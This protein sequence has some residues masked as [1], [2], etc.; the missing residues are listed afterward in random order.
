M[1][2]AGL[3]TSP[4][5]PDALHVEKNSTY[6]VCPKLDDEPITSTTEII[7]SQL[8]TCPYSFTLTLPTFSTAAYGLL[9][10]A[11]RQTRWSSSIPETLIPSTIAPPIRQ[12]ILQ[13]MPTTIRANTE[14]PRLSRDV[15]SITSP[16]FAGQRPTKCY[17]TFKASALYTVLKLITTTEYRYQH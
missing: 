16:A 5:G 9:L 7:P 6:P 10:L 17:M 2:S 3:P 15:C 11:N 12:A 14:A 1:Q 4:D 13:H 8:H